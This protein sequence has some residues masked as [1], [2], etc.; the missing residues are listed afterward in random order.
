MDWT[1]LLEH[2]NGILEW[3]TGLKLT[4][5]QIKG[6]GEMRE[7]NCYRDHKIRTVTANTK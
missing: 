2:W 7:A 5:S 3:N 6:V 1:G 4:S